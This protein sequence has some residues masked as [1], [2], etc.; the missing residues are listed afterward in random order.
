ME[1]GPGGPPPL[2]QRLHG[3]TEH[4]EVSPF[5]ACGHLAARLN[6]VFLCLT[7]CLSCVLRDQKHTLGDGCLVMRPKHRLGYPSPKSGF[8]VYVRVL[9]TTQ[10]AA[11]QPKRHL[12]SLRPTRDT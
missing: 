1:A 7:S 12:G 5:P 9:L 3:T 4:V 10:L 11:A 6:A 8:L 2:L